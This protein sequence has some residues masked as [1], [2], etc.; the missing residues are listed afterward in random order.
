MLMMSEHCAPIGALTLDKYPRRKASVG[1]YT[2]CGN[3]R[4]VTKR[5]EVKGNL[6]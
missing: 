2:L 5:I 6:K 3:V 1:I 4:P